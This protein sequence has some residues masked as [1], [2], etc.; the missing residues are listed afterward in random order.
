MD[1]FLLQWRLYNHNI[2]NSNLWSIKYHVY[3]DQQRHVTKK[4]TDSSYVYYDCRGATVGDRGSMAWMPAY[5]AI[6]NLLSMISMAGSDMCLKFHLYLLSKVCQTR[7][8]SL[9]F[10]SQIL[11]LFLSALPLYFEKWAIS[12]DQEARTYKS[13]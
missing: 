1:P 10:F 11:N 3:A 2:R 6:N 9:S 12:S 5:T 13:L 4:I 8:F 7:H